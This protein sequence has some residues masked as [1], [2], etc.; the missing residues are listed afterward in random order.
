MPTHL[1]TSVRSDLGA[2]YGRSRPYQAFHSF[3]K[4]KQQRGE[5]R[6]WFLLLYIRNQSK[7]PRFLGNE[8]EASNWRRS[9]G[10]RTPTMRHPR[11]LIADFLHGGF[12]ASSSSPR[13]QVAI[14]KRRLKSQPRFGFRTTSERGCRGDA[15][16]QS[17]QR[18][19]STFCKR[20]LHTRRAGSESTEKKAE[21]AIETGA[22]KQTHNACLRRRGKSA[23]NSFRRRSHFPDGK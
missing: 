17:A 21:K 23:P 19:E 9:L 5:A 18:A 12:V 1:P 14:P 22:A 15:T 2:A 13:P 20:E 8:K 3:K 11:R 16:I 6:R 7:P 4:H 10:E